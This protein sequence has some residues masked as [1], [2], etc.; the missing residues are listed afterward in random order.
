MEL[1]QPLVWRSHQSSYRHCSGKEPTAV[2]CKEVDVV[3]GVLR[4]MLHIL[5][6]LRVVHIRSAEKVC[7]ELGE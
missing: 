4:W 5:G 3:E 6:Y 2:D 7:Q 1:V